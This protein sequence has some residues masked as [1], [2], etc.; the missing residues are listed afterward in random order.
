M[1]KLLWTL[2]VLVIGVLALV[3]CGGG[4]SGTSGTATLSGPTDTPLP[5]NS[6]EAQRF[7]LKLSELPE[8]WT[9]TSATEIAVGDAVPGASGW[10]SSFSNSATGETITSKMFVYEENS[11]VE[12]PFGAKYDELA[13]LSG[14]TSIPQTGFSAF[15]A[16]DEASSSHLVWVWRKSAL[17]SMELTTSSDGGRADVIKKAKVLDDRIAQEDLL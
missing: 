15:Y 9:E 5:V 8:G 12:A 11:Q 13:A 16:N 3:A 6:S 2:P 17:F 14:L 7:S 10:E 4:S 1:N